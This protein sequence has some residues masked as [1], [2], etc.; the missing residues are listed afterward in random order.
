MTQLTLFER[1][2]QQAD[3]DVQALTAALY[4]SKTW[5]TRAQLCRQFRWSERRLRM[6]GENSRGIVIFGQRGMRHIRWASV[7][8]VHACRNTLF[9]QARRNSQRAVEVE[10]AFHQ[11]GSSL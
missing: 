1:R 6:A 10:R 3:Q 9:S 11:L 2:I 8:E 4:G 5:Q 7:D